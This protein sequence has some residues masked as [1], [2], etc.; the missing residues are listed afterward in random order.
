[1]NRTT[2]L[3]RAA[4]AVSRILLQ[5]RDLP[6]LLQGLCDHL[7]KA[8]LYQAALV[9]LMDRDSGAMITAET[10][11]GD[12]F[13][14]V[15]AQLRQ[16]RLPACGI[17]VL[18]ADS[19]EV[20]LCTDCSCSM[21][22]EDAT[23]ALCA[24]LRCSPS[25]T[26]FLTVPLLPAIQ[27]DEDEVGLIGELAE[28]ITL[29]LRQLFAEVAARNRE[30]ELQRSEER[31]ELA[32]H[33]SQAGLWDWNIKTGEM[34]TSPDH[35]ELLDYRA[36][37]EHQ[38]GPPRFI[39]PEDR[40]RVLSVLN[41]HL[42]GKTDEYRIEYRVNDPD[43][44]LTWYLDRGRVVERDENNMPVRMTGTHQNITLQKRQDEAL[45]LLERQLHEAVDYERNFL[46][47]VIDSAGDPVMAIDLDFNL[48]LINRAAASLVRGG[49]DV[50]SMQGQKCY[51]LFHDAK[52]PC[53]DSRFP[54]PVVEIRTGQ[55][56]MKLIHN[57]YH[58]N[59]VRNTF[60][61][62][63]S[64]LRD[65][66]GA[67]YGI[68]EVA[69]DITD[70]LRIEKDLRD[71]QSHLY[72]LAHHDTLTGL[73]NRLL[74][75][76]RLAQAISK[77]ERNRT[78]V[79]VLFLDL[80]RFKIINDTLGHDV[81][82]G[83]LAEVAGRLQRQCRQS[84]TV[85]R[86]GGDE[87]VFV[88]EAIGRRHDAAVVATKIMNAMTEPV[89]V[90]HHELKISTSIGIALYPDD[91][92]DGEELLKC[93]DM[94]L[95]A[96]KETGRNTFEHYRR[97]LPRN[98]QR[99]QLSSDP[100]QAALAGNQFVFQFLPQYE[101]RH[102]QL[103]GFKS[104]LSWRHPEMGVLLP[105]AFIADA[106]TCGMLGALSAW[107]FTDVCRS[108]YSWRQAGGQILPVTVQVASRQLLDQDFPIMVAETA[109]RFDIPPGMLV[110]EVRER[111][112]AIGTRLDLE[113]L[114]T[115]ARCG[116]VLGLRDFGA[117]GCPLV[118]L[119]Q[120][121]L[122]RVALSRS[123]LN[124]VAAEENAVTL[125]NA[126]INLCHGLGLAVLADGVEEEAQLNVLRRCGCD[127]VQGPLLAAPL[128]KDKAGQLLLTPPRGG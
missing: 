51:Q 48:L 86:L 72:R 25:L 117:A 15:M 7:T 50:A 126:L 109:N 26:G 100:F 61:L 56:Q 14:S 104:Q 57:P 60:E 105:D 65:G 101:A 91:A 63:V 32:L 35:W 34:Y 10:N 120:L 62:D 115:I 119:Q 116:V 67:L 9:V 95:Y 85:A 31:Y 110:F 66:R 39:H 45:N 107:I 19:E 84:D 37:T 58:G 47:T 16:G 121:P 6:T 93:A 38:G 118:R 73:P 106:D 46:Q 82:D 11:L 42:L 30:Q 17:R 41:E 12:R 74:F 49:G 122:Q 113:R 127:F 59:A 111:A 78:G 124:G 40:E 89:T 112:L 76:D 79:A 70:R 52:E 29:A 90:G 125:I 33:A 64:P 68:I 4:Y 87:F 114:T 102:N 54:C 128:D 77:A 94:A 75:Q 103:V 1:M 28:S 123:L 23:L 22:G 99:P 108:L 18:E 2:D 88:L 20:V 92:G 24:P 83:L 71:S 13:E 80:D 21:C 8:G 53:R 36:D 5:E 44:G 43:R 55:R 98:G 69:R 97:D 81:G 3:L 27:P 96:A